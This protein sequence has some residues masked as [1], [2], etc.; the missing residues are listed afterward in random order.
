MAMRAWTVWAAAAI[1]A[2]V[3][4]AAAK[5]PDLPGKPEVNGKVPSPLAQQHYQA[6][7]LPPPRLLPESVLDPKPAHGPATAGGPT[8]PLPVPFLL[9]GF[10]RQVQK[11][12]GLDRAR[13]HLLKVQA[14]FHQAEVH[15]D[16]C[17]TED[18]RQWYREVIR[19][20]PGTP[21][22]RIADERLRLGKVFPAGLRQTKEPPLADG[23]TGQS[24][25][26]RLRIP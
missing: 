16:A 22:A 26:P 14:A 11:T 18:A 10:G 7:T 8:E 21:F 6:E 13:V 23:P 25:L 2:G 9:A 12:T 24:D 17:E 20:A 4:S 1:L 3:I 5:P 19:L 15:F